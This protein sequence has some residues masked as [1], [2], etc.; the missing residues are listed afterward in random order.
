MSRASAQAVLW[1]KF[2]FAPVSPVEEVPSSEEETAEP[3]SADDALVYEVSA[4]GEASGS[5]PEDTEE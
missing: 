4:G 5:I 1:I 3:E 2:K